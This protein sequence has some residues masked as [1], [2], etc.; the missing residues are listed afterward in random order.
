MILSVE[1]K[2]DQA[3]NTL[4]TFLANAGTVGGTVFPIKNVNGFNQNWAFQLGKTGEAQAEI[5]INPNS[6]TG[7]TVLNSSGS[8]LYAHQIDTPVYQ[9][10]Y[11]KVIFY[12][13][14]A[15]TTGSG[16]PLSN[17]TVS[18]TPSQFYTEYND[19]TATS[20]YGYQAQFYNSLSGQQTNLSSY[21]FSTGATFYSL[22]KLRDRAKHDLYSANYIKDD[23]TIDDWINE[24]LEIMTNSMIKVN[25][26][27][28]QGTVIYP[29]GP[30]SGSPQV[31][32][33]TITDPLFVRPVKLEVSYDGNIWTTSTE[34]KPYQFSSQDFYSAIYPCH[35][36]Q[37][38]NVFGVLPTTQSGSAKFTYNLRYA[39]LVN[40]TD[41]VPLILKGYT[42][43]CIEYVLHKAYSLDQKDDT[44][45]AHFQKFVLYQNAFVSEIT[46]RDLTS[47]KM[48][49]MS[50]SISGMNEDVTL[51]TEYFV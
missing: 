11:D 27:Y 35:Y 12:R 1:N 37:G 19:P 15:G 49:N 32:L 2:L 6:P 50:D 33:G 13:N 4:V 23:N 29:F 34:L 46:P 24:W 25:Q 16:T 47:E 20:T 22:Q 38:D 18:I 7:G 31:C 43:S 30:P 17:G 51:I 41:E 28:A 39:P 14:I 26:G 3:P 8:A 45:D 5:L 40:D 21:F 10:N 42:T 48:I 36:W 9:I 44:A